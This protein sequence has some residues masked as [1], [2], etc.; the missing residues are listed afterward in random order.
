MALGWP[1][2]NG[3]IGLETV[4]LDPASRPVNR[5]A[6]QRKKDRI[7]AKKIGTRSADARPA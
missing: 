7:D 6:K 2:F 1:W 4:V 3:A 5:K